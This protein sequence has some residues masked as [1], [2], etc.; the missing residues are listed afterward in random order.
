VPQIEH[1]GGTNHHVLVG[2][3]A[4]F[5][6]SGRPGATRWSPHVCGQYPQLGSGEVSH[7]MERNSGNNMQVPWYARSTK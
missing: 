2:R 3:V 1:A 5:T 4:L 6:S 7:E